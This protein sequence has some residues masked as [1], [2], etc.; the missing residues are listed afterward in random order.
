MGPEEGVLA[1]A[2]RLPRNVAPRR[3]RA[4]Q[5]ATR[6]GA[7]RRNY[8][9]AELFS[10]KVVAMG[11]GGTPSWRTDARRFW[12]PAFAGMTSEA[13]DPCFRRDDRQEREDQESRRG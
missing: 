1:K 8:F 6:S 12:I 10:E 7:S 4:T 5:T 3:V 13:L 2:F 9:F 11:R